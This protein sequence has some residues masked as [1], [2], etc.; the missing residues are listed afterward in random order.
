MASVI[1]AML[2]PL[3]AYAFRGTYGQVG[4][5]PF[6]SF[7]IGALVVFMHRENLKR[8]FEGKESKTYFFKKKK[9]AEDENAVVEK[10]K[11]VKLE[12]S[13]PE[14]VYS[15]KDFVKC[16]CGR[17]IPITRKNCIYCKAENKFYTPEIKQDKKK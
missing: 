6:M 17:I 2:L 16:S 12:T 15:D 5:I 10:K 7:F 13:E 3:T 1:S 8:L 4:L 14:K 11:S 9:A